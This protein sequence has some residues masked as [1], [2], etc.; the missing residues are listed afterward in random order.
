MFLS[1]LNK[2]NIKD[3][4]EAGWA[5]TA[6]KGVKSPYYTYFSPVQLLPIFHILPLVTYTSCPPSPPSPPSTHTPP[7]PPTPP[8]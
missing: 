6:W 7:S 5:H 3:N 8:S 4:H 2:E 1:S